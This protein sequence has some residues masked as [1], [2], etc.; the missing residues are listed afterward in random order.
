MVSF[1]AE[2]PIYLQLMGEIKRQIAAG[3]LPAGAKIA[4]I[5]ELA[6][7]YAVNPNTV[8]RSLFE[9]EREG[10]LSTK[11]ASGK[12]VTEDTEM[13]RELRE[14]LAAERLEACLS[15]LEALGFGEAE[16]AARFAGALETWKTRKAREISG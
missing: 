7:H 10:L 15:A 1:H 12:T 2:T 16:T 11:R 9:L 6:A 3:E 8:Q 13:I 5:R 4:S 14:H